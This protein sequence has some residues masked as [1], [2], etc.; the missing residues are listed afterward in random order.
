VPTRLADVANV[1][2]R[3]SDGVIALDRNWRY[4]YVNPQ[5]AR[6]LD[7]DHPSDLIGKSAL[8]EFPDAMAQPWGQAYAQALAT[9]QPSVLEMHDEPAN[10]WFLSRIY[11]SADGLTVYITE[12]TEQK[13]TEQ[14][15]RESIDRAR[16]AHRMES[17]GRLAGGIA[18]DFNNLLTVINN[19]AELL[20]DNVANDDKLLERV[21]TI[22][23]AG[24]RAAL[25]TQQLLAFSR[26]QTLKPVILQLGTAVNEMVP[27]LRR[28]IGVHIELVVTADPALA[29]VSAD[30]G[31]IDQVIM[32][33]VVNARDAMPDGGRLDITLSNA[34]LDESHGDSRIQVVPGPYVELRVQDSGTGMPAATINRIFEPFYTTKELTK[35]TGLGLPTAYG[36]IKQSGGYIW[37]SSVEGE[38]TTFRVYLPAVSGTPEVQQARSGGPP[39]RGTET[40]LIVEDDPDVRTLTALITSA[41][42]Y[43]I[44]V[45]S[46]GAAALE[47]LATRGAEVDLV[48]TDVIMPGMTGRRFAEEVAARWP[49][50]RLLFM[51]GYI[52]DAKRTIGPDEQFIGKPFTGDALLRKVRE[53]LDGS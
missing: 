33:L 34:T 23:R 42:G 44:M 19:S 40:I 29:S 35:G 46:S 50:T 13:R 22:R 53:M 37:V 25:L 28:L 49:G 45:A 31:Q 27:M 47:V 11:P 24:G 38:G 20:V 14:K 9:Q 36:I 48:L 15:L 41:A 43:T 10:R 3:I 7:R 21:L 26:Q 6:V 1:F 18:H 17:V 51:S 30:P 4:T 5:A 39:P 12:I 32:N 8:T 52:D 16:L 2:E